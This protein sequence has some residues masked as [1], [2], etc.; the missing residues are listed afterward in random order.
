[1]FQ[2]RLILLIEVDR[3]NPLLNIA[4]LLATAT[5]IHQVMNVCSG[6]HATRRTLLH[7]SLGVLYVGHESP[8][9]GSFSQNFLLSLCRVVLYHMLNIKLFQFLQNLF[10]TNLRL[11]TD[12]T[13]VFF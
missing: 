9:T 13:Q 3:I 2:N 4:T 6:Q 12:H 7:T 5:I 1:M 10:L 8:L 11:N